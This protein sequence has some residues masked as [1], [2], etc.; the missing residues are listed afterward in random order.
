MLSACVVAAQN[1]RFKRQK[2]K[3]W[4][5]LLASKAAGTMAWSRVKRR[6][7]LGEDPESVG[8]GVGKDQSHQHLAELLQTDIKGGYGE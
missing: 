7:L 5:F 8:G 1:E 4:T 3:C 2:R 6:V